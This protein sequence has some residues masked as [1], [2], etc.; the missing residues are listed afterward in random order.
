MLCAILTG[1]P[2]YTG[3][4]FEEV[5]R[6]ARRGDVADARGRLDASGADPALIAL[7]QECLAPE[8][9][10]RPADAGVLAG[11]VA[12]YQ[13]AVQEL[14][15]VADRARAAAEAGRRGANVDCGSLAWRRH[16]WA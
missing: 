3:R 14:L 11:R 15:K 7:A 16:R 12:A 1:Q 10:D 13:S 2:A 5:S 4:S 8:P 9:L 6:K